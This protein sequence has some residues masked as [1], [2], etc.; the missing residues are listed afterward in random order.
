MILIW[1]PQTRTQCMIWFTDLFS[2]GTCRLG[3][4]DCPGHFGHI[5][6]SSPC[7]NPITFKLM[8][9]LLNSAC[10]YCHK[11]RTSRTQLYHIAAKLR[12]AHVGLVIEAT[13]LDQHVM[14][15]WKASTTMQADKGD[16]S[17][18]DDEAMDE[19]EDEGQGFA[20][21][22][23]GQPTTEAEFITAIDRYV[24]QCMKKLGDSEVRRIIRRNTLITDTTRAIEKMFLAT[25]P[26]GN[27]ANCR[28][29][30]PKFRAEGMVKIFQKPLTAKQLKQMKSKG[31]SLAVLSCHG[32]QCISSK[33]LTFLASFRN[34]TFN[35]KQRFIPAI[36]AREH[37]NRLW[38]NEI[39]I[40]DLLYGSRRKRDSPRVS[41]YDMF[42]VSA[43]PVPPNKFRP[44]SKMGD[45]LFE[46]PQNNYLT[47]VIKSNIAIV[48][49][50]SAEVVNSN[51]RML[52]ALVALQTGVNNFI[53][54]SGAPNVNGKL[55]SP[56]IRQLLE[57]KDGLFRKHMMGKR[58]NYA[59]RSVISPDPNIE[60]SEIGVCFSLLILRS[61]LLSPLS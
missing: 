54:S 46:H 42:F 50:Q 10:L 31:M 13:E 34:D 20:S 44:L 61:H 58:V 16:I 9:K 38:E 3:Y 28:G 7:Y 23:T 15:K 55:A 5:E 14:F 4:F 25:I 11:F 19:D 59:A 17:M 56:G 12:L 40:L 36:E 45:Q 47:E 6:L 60:T 33:V 18:I 24:D 51:E 41:H 32:V 27:C 35:E 30:S 1:V 39:E 26:A 57:K 53:D 2:C 49:S 8:M 21:G 43:L 22:E 52:N 37:M 48:E 29:A